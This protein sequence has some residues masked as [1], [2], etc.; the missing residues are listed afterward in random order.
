[1]RLDVGNFSA[2]P[3]G[4]ELP[5]YEQLLENKLGR[6]DPTS[7]KA[8]GLRKILA[9]LEDHGD[10]ERALNEVD[11]FLARREDVL[12]RTRFSTI[13]GQ[14][15]SPENVQQEIGNIRRAMSNPDAFLGN[16]AV[17]NV[18]SMQSVYKHQAACVKVV[19]DYGMLSLGNSVDREMGFLADLQDVIVSGVRCPMPLYSFSNIQMHGYAMEQLNAYNFRRIIDGFTTNGIPDR[20]PENFDIDD[21]FS[22]LQQYLEHIHKMG[23]YHGDIFLRNLMVGRENALPYVIDFGKGRRRSE[24]DRTNVNAPDFAASD[25]ARMFSA[26]AELQKWITEQK[27]QKK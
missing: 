21:Y 2:Y 11:Q 13:E 8:P 25:I 12:A 22:R 10:Y 7:L 16:G 15:I 17:A 26:K 19:H 1:M 18:F 23:I 20:L 3:S 4:E 9:L 24:L 5:D 14:V 27:K 6:L